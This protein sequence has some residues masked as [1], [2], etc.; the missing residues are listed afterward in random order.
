M[1]VRPIQGR[2][3]E[4]DFGHLRAMTDERGLFEHARGRQPAREFGYCVDDA[5]RALLV[6]SIADVD[7]S[8][9]SLRGVY[10]DVTLRAVSPDGRCRNRL[11]PGG[12]WEDEPGLG[13]WWGRALWGLGVA[14][15]SGR[16]GHS[17]ALAAFDTLAQVRSQWRRSMAY[18]ALGAAAVV[19]RTASAEPLLVDAVDAVTAH[20]GRTHEG[21]WPEPCLTYDNAILPWALLA[22]GSALG[23]DDLTEQGLDWLTFLTEAQLRDGHL[24]V[25]PAGGRALNARPPGFDQQ[26]I[27]VASL[28]GA[29]ALAYDL[30]GDERWRLLVRLAGE[31]FVGNNDVGVALVDPATGAGQDGLTPTGPNLNCGA[32]STLAA[33]LTLALARHLGAIEWPPSSPHIPTSTSSPI[34]TG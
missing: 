23:R 1:S 11:S 26:P 22:A 34:L 21:G 6:T 12:I 25:V 9:A 5:A 17:D 32:E 14:S 27:E 8:L 7:G 4:P 33:N 13:D 30:T 15:A 31:W 18:A 16:E 10:L 28:A 24:S 2:L 3:P 20:D 19:E 29:A